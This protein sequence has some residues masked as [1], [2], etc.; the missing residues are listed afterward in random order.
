MGMSP[1]MGH[2]IISEGVATH[3]SDHRNP[4]GWANDPVDPGI[5]GIQAGAGHAMR[6]V[7]PEKTGGPEYESGRSCIVTIGSGGRY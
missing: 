3:E 6:T 5:T 1:V 2:V 4:V 7:L